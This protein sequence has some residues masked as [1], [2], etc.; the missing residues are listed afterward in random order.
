[1]EVSMLKEYCSRESFTESYQ[2]ANLNKVQNDSQVKINRAVPSPVQK[3]W[4][5]Y[6]SNRIQS[7]T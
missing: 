6:D 1:M 5:I 4:F 7:I 3:L 2:R